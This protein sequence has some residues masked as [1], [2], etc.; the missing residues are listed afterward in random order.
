MRRLVVIVAFL[1][2]G[3]TA[4]AGDPNPRRYYKGLRVHG[5]NEHA[6]TVAQALWVLEG[7]NCMEI[8][9]FDSR[10]VEWFLVD[11]VF[12]LH[13]SRFGGGMERVWVDAL[14]VTLFFPKDSSLRVWIDRRHIHKSTLWRHEG[15]HAGLYQN[16]DYGERHHTPQHYACEEEPSG[17]AR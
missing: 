9:E 5:E 11:S 16:G 6:L 14:G 7:I 4:L 13:G 8:D 15:I 1:V 10:V 3:C 17:Q 2:L 12:T